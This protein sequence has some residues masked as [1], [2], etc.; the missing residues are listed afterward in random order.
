MILNNTPH[1]GNRIKATMRYQLTPV[2][3]A[4]INNRGNRFCKV[5][6]KG[7]T[8]TLLVAMQTV[9]AS[10]ENSMEVPQIVKNRATL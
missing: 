9:A 2:T 8:L 6:R 5:Q 7:N 10:P 3:M 1:Q 4:K